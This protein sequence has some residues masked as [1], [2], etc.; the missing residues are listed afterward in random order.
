MHHQMAM[1]EANGWQ[2][3]FVTSATNVDRD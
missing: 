2:E 1:M 3:E